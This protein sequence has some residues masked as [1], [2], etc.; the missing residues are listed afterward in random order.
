MRNE[1]SLRTWL[2]RFNNRGFKAKD[3]GTQIEIG[4]YDWF[5]KDSSL[6]NK[7]KRMGNIIK[8]FKEGGKITLE[9]HFVQ[10]EKY[11]PLNGLL[12]DDFRIAEIETNETVFTVQINNSRE[13][14]RFIIYGKMNNFENH[15][16]QI[17]QLK[18]L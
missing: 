8:Q 6:A 17:T 11:S 18:L 1:V 9:Q 3:V 10:F 4:W 2:A 12:Y 15:C 7:T 5:C 16:S 13:E 14:A